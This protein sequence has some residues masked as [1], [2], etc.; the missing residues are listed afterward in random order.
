LHNTN[1]GPNIRLPNNTIIKAT[2]AGHLCNI[3]LP[4]A[5]TKTHIFPD[6]KIASL[7]SIG[8]LCDV[9]CEAVFRKQDLKIYDERRQLVLDEKRNTNDRLWD[10]DLPPRP[11]EPTVNAVLRLDQTKVELA[12]YLHASCFSP[13]PSTFIK[14]INKSHFTTWPGLTADLIIKHLPPSTATVKGHIKQEFKNIRST[15]TAALPLTEPDSSENADKTDTPGEQ[16]H[17]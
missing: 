6:L 3:T 11:P 10:I 17:E 2:Q 13:V 4:A 5:A 14:A 15:Q 8:Q 9:G 12:Q 16:V 1:T 7:V